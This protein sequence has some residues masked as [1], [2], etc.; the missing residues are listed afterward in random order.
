[1]FTDYDAAQDDLLINL[2]VQGGAS[3][4]LG[5]A[6]AAGGA[7]TIL[8]Y[9]GRDIAQFGGAAAVSRSDMNLQ[10]VVEGG[11]NT[12]FAATTQADFVRFAATNGS[13]STLGGD[14]T[15]SLRDAGAVAVDAGAGNDVIDAHGGTLY[16]PLGDNDAG[17]LTPAAFDAH[18]DTVLGGDGRD[19]LILRN[20]GVAMGGSGN[21]IFA[22]DH[23]LGSAA[24][25][26]VLPA[27][28]ITDFNPA[29]DKIELDQS[30]I[31][32]AAPASVSIAIWAN[33]VGADILVG[34][35]VIAKVT[36]G[37]GLTANDLTYADRNP[38]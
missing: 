7:G 6:P 10:F 31:A 14:D 1:M 20:G 15:I 21:D 16:G 34:S 2:H 24:Y 27:A 35:A 8:S 28:E 9:A 32:G 4:E 11:E 22:V 13:V 18:A 12:T 37:Q 25:G 17:G 26:L 29:Q 23:A 33:G 36:G 19:L 5:F 30:M 3:G 38:V